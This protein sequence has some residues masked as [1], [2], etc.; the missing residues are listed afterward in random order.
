[1]ITLGGIPLTLVIK[2][3]VI[4]DLATGTFGIGLSLTLDEWVYLI[5]TDGSNASYLLPIS[6]WGGVVMIGLASLYIF[7]LYFFSK[8]T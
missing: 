4:A 6:F 3:P 7:L 5:S 1:M 2:K 8:K